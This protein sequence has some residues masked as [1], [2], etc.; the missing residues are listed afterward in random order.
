MLDA[1]NAWAISRITARLGGM[2]LPIELAAA[3]VKLLDPATILARLDDQLGLLASS[4]RD[5]PE[6]PRT[7]RGA[8]AWSVELLTEAERTLFDR[9]G[10]FVGGFEFRS[11]ATVSADELLDDIAIEDVIASLVDQSLVQRI[12]G[13]PGR[14]S[15]LEP[16]REFAL[17]RLAKRGELE[18]RRDRH[19]AHFLAL[20]E[21]AAP[22]LASAEQRTW[23]DRLVTERDNLRAAVGWAVDAPRPAVAI[24]LCFALWRFW[25]KRGYV[26][27]AAARLTKIV[28]AP[29]SRGDPGLYAKALE[30]LGG[31]RYRQGQFERA[32]RSYTEATRIWRELGDRR[33]IANALYNESFTLGMRAPSQATPLLE[34]AAAIYRDL[35]DDLGLAK[36]LWAEATLL[37]R[38][39]DAPLRVPDAP[40]ATS[41]LDEAR[42]IFSR[43]GERTMEAWAE[44][45]LGGALTSADRL[46]EAQAMFDR[47]LEHFADVGDVA[48]LSIAFA[49][50][51]VVA[52]RE[53]DLE[54]SARLDI[55]G[56]D[57]GISTSVRLMEAS[58]G[59]FANVWVATTPAEL[60]PGR[61]A[62]LQAEVGTWS[63]DD[64]L[65]YARAGSVR[66]GPTAGPAAAPTAD[67]PPPGR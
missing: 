42:T 15:L 46:D 53:G 67:G 44:H 63:L 13:A 2:P 26:D 62:E 60:P 55:A 48:G 66:A 56:R 18:D 30:S 49:D 34:E 50:Q 38:V 36:V 5:L 51:A 41:R 25:Q 33:E 16:I 11:A 39:P 6:R 45:M 22:H 64:M 24:R 61:Y 4:A 10:V 8:I 21:E 12:P 47:A 29:R 40:A 28:A 23:L 9:L 19:A 43:A 35:G 58:A 1:T 7:M 52:Y 57:V 32:L 27:E 20:A 14:G 17:E 31:I 65:S 59:E 54:R 3:R 37:L